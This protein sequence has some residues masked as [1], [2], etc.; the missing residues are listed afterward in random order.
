MNGSERSG[1]NYFTQLTTEQVTTTFVRASTRPG[2]FVR[3]LASVN[4]PD[5]PEEGVLPGS[6]DNHTEG[7]E[8]K[9]NITWPIMAFPLVRES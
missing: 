1:R 9:K 8:A 6:R 7:F 2:C 3:I 4:D 5:D